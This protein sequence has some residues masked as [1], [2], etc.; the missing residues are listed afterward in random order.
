M[1]KPR[2][3]FATGRLYLHATCIA[4]REPLPQF[5]ECLFD[6]GNQ[7]EYMRQKLA[8]ALDAIA[9]ADGKLF[10]LS[11]DHSIWHAVVNGQWD[12]IQVCALRP[13]FVS[14]VA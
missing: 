10:V 7:R 3:I 13:T 11:R 1:S 12:I 14:T 8:N 6:I 9:T 4:R 5:H 2:A